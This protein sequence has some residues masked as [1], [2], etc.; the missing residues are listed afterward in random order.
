MVEAMRGVDVWVTALRRGQSAT[1]AGLKR[2][3]WD[4]NY[5]V[6]KLNPLA[7]WTRPQVWEYIQA[8]NVPYNPLHK[9]GY[10]SIGCTHCTVRVEGSRPDQ[11][12]RSGRWN[13]TEKTECGL[14]GYGI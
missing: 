8:N 9:E 12:T 10:P 7:D 2:V 5:Q 1:R 3:E 6:V 14:H 13:G 11:Y 4:W